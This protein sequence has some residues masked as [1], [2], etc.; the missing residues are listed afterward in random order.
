MTV[1]D[2][3]LR[4]GLTNFN[5]NYTTDAHSQ[6]TTEDDANLFNFINGDFLANDTAPAGTCSPEIA[7]G[8][9]FDFDA[10]GNFGG[11]TIFNSD[12]AAEGGY[13]GA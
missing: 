13:Y 12:G 8:A 1:L 10:A 7:D 3:E 11:E 6:N 2:A 9:V 5:N 4:D